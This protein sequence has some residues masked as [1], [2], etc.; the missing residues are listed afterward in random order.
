MSF[1][2]CGRLGRPHGVR[3]ALRIWPF[4]VDTDL[5]RTKRVLTIG[6][7]PK[8]TRPL[9]VRS[10]RRDAKGWIVTFDGI[11]DRDAAAHLTNATWFETREDFGATDDDEVFIAD[12]LGLAVALESGETLGTIA[13]VW[14]AGAAD[15]LVIRGPRGEQLVPNVPEFVVRLDPA[16]PPAIVRPIEGLL[17]EA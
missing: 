17:N 2:A 13:D 4:N 1:I 16:N 14:Q 11:A 8:R 12:L 9:T 3:G 15:V 5:I 6:P 7:S 10:A